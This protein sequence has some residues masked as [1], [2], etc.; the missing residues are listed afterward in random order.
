M[1]EKFF[2]RQCKLRVSAF[3][4]LLFLAVLAAFAT[5]KNVQAQETLPESKDN[6]TYTFTS[7]GDEAVSTKA[8]PGQT[9]VLVFGHTKCSYTRTTLNSLSSC[10]W[11]KRADV[12]VIFVETEGHTKEEVHS[13]EQGYACPDM[14]FCYSEEEDN[15]MA[16]VGYSQL[17][18]LSGG[19][20]PMIVL[21]DPYN[22]VRNILSGTK[23][24]DE[25]LTEIKKF[26]PI[27][28]EG[29]DT[30]S[31]PSVGIENFAYGLHTTDDTVVS[32]K[33]NPNQTTVLLFGYT[34]CGLTK[35]T[36]KEIS[37]S[38]LVGRAN[39]RVIFADV[40]GASLEETKAFAQEFAGSGIVFCHDKDMLN[41]N[42]AMSY[43]NLY[44]YTGGTFPY[45]VLIDQNNKIRNITLGPKTAD[46]IRQEILKFASLDQPPTGG[47]TTPPTGGDTTPPAEG[48]DPLPP[49]DTPVGE[50]S[51]VV[52]L[53]AVSEA[54]NVKLSW[55]AVS[56]ADG[57]LVYQYNTSK[58]TWVKKATLKGNILSYKVKGLTPATAYRFA[59][60]AYAQGADGEQVSSK[61]YTSLY[62]ATAPNA[63]NFT[64]KAGRKKAVLSWKKVKGATGYTVYYKTK[65]NGD[66][67][68]LKNTKGTSYT[69]TKLK[70]GT[71]YYFTVKAY[72][73]YKKE[74]YTSAF[75]SR[76]VRVK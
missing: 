28:V 62:T 17:Y 33:A 19:K 39:L 5:G 36:L 22:R 3:F 50:L 7:T 42:F 67:K 18:G 34:T 9:T 10:E 20:Y 46:E 53:K 11:V 37:G 56:N 57:Y 45:M 58:K 55:S 61:S 35:A 51:D 68:K 27:D 75:K 52:G 2:T 72:K 14:T 8:N 32:T 4:M 23:T 44:H 54:K 60:K 65:A 41:F 66:W 69:K 47:D 1:S 24:S 29:S 38:D 43:L 16:M 59:V 31:D 74:T 26:Q 70:S 49:A 6:L 40:Y 30:P 63:V 64:V 21:I 13:Y 73:T 71:T 15:F 76:K 48:D 25:V 12:R